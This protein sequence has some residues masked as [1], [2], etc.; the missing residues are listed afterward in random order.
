MIQQATGCL[1]QV[2]GN[3]TFSGNVGDVLGSVA[4]YL[5]AFGQI[6]IYKN[7]HLTF[8]NN[9]GRLVTHCELKLKIAS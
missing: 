8:N 5:S 4:M 6:K 1:L 3:V 7:C 2:K 9:T